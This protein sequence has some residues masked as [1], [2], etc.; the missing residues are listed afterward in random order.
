VRRQSGIDEILLNITL[1]ID[2]NA[3]G[4]KE[5]FLGVSI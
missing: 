3:D 4:E 1:T 5:A 2:R